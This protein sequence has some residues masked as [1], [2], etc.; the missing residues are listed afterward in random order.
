MCAT[1]RDHTTREVD[2]HQKD[3]RREHP[4]FEASN[5]ERNRE[6]LKPLERWFFGRVPR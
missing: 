2:E 3:R 1:G 5:I 6:L 4:R